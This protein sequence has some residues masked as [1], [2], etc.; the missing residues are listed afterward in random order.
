MYIYTC[1]WLVA[2]LVHYAWVEG[3]LLPFA[4]WGAPKGN[5]LISTWSSTARTARTARTVLR[6]TAQHSPNIL[7]KARI[8]LDKAR[9]Y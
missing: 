8:K 7:G 5:V 4:S 3:A 9:Q 6:S 2:V 1:L